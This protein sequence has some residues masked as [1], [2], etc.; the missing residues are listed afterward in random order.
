[1][2]KIV[3]NEQVVMLRPWQVL[4]RTV[5]IGGA[6]GA[7]F[8]VLSLLLSQFVI[9]PLAC[10]G[11][12]EAVNCVNSVGI[13][14]NIALIFTTVLSILVLARFLVLQP[15]IISVGTALLLWNFGNWVSGLFWLESLSWAVL[16]YAAC[17]GLFAWIVRYH[18]LVPALIIG[19]VV[20]LLIHIL[21]VV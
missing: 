8:W 19:L 9:E 16:L 11:A 14:S 21:L 17:F 15:I 10:R 2:A 20:V 18:R 7:I 1:M 4:L 12:S 13:A 5:L 6:I 3:H